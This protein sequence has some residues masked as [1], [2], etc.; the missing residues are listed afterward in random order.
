MLINLIN[1]L[2][3]MKK[4]FCFA[5]L[6]GF[7]LLYSGDDYLKWYA[8]FRV[9]ETDQPD[10]FSGTEIYY[11]IYNNSS[12]LISQR[13]SILLVNTSSNSTAAAT[14]MIDTYQYQVLGAHSFKTGKTVS[15]SVFFFLFILKNSLNVA[16]RVKTYT[17]NENYG[18]NGEDVSDFEQFRACIK[19][20]G[21]LR[22][23]VNG[24]TV[25]VGYDFSC[26]LIFF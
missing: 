20:S 16:F 1:T 26:W 11:K 21:R 19:F 13:N 9:N 17:G 25:F 15:Q 3:V 18:A 14:R 5:P 7:A 12:D 23:F 6:F 4:R 8:S 2:K 24:S 22:A 10:S